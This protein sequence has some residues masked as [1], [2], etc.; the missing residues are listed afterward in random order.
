MSLG[1]A[2]CAYFSQSAMK[3]ESHW[4]TPS[5][6][7]ASTYYSLA[8]FQEAGGRRPFSMAMAQAPR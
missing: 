6:K 3:Q 2:P 4:K 8:G 7:Q 1:T 5:A